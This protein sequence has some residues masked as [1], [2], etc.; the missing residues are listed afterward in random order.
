MTI[1]V[2][3]GNVEYG[4]TFGMVAVEEMQLRQLGR[5]QVAEPTGNTRALTDMFYCSHNN[6]NDNQEP[7]RPRISYKSASEIIE[8][9]VYSGDMP[10]QVMIVDSFQNCRA[11]RHLREQLEGAKKKTVKKDRAP[12]TTQG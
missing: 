10:T 2:S 11:T 9:L 3:I 12:R 5:M 8:E 6:F 7:Q 1:T 4:L